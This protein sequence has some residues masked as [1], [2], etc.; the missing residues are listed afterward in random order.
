M[1]VVSLG[2]TPEGFEVLMDKTAAEADGVIVM[3]RVKTHTGF[4]GTIESGLLKMIVVG[5][6][7]VKG[8][9]EFHRWARQFG[10]EPVIRAISAQVLASGKVLAGLGVIENQLHQIAAVRAA[11]PEE[12]AA[13]EEEMLRLARPLVPRIPFAGFHVLMVDE[14]GKDISGT[15]MDTK[16]I[17]R[18]LILQ[19]GEAPEIRM[20]YVR[21]LTAESGGNAVGVGWADMIHERIYKKMDLQKTY[22]NARTALNPLVTRVPIH[23]PSDREAL[24]L[25][26]GHLG[27][28]D[29]GEQRVVWIKN[30][31]N[32]NRIA[33]SRPLAAE[34]SKLAGWQLT[35]EPFA[36]Q[37]DAE[38]NVVSAY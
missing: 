2:A 38:G 9:T 32:L 1:E 35:G 23:L 30:T 20:I 29:P 25:A 27:V 12:L 19:P 4:S 22:L 18:G 21:D 8:A 3:N 17:G 13:A 6:G 31:L 11:R 26:L 24:D 36:P 14:M 37:F 7:K 34:A 10:F 33:I 15:G 5:M 16:S 28:T